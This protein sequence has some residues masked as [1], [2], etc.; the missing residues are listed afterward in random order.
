MQLM[1]KNP[2]SKWS[3]GLPIG[4]GRLAAMVWGSVQADVLTLNHEWLWRGT[5]RNRKV[6][7]NA[8]K[9]PFVRDLL[10]RGEFF[11]AG[12]FANLYFGGDGG[13]SGKPNN[14]DP[15]VP[16]G[17]LTFCFD[18]DAQ[19]SGRELDINTGIAETKR[20]LS[21][22]GVTGEFYASCVS[23]L[24]YAKWESEAP[25]SGTLRL[26]REHE[27]ITDIIIKAGKNK[28]TL[29]GSINNGQCF[30]IDV[31]IKTDGTLSKADDG[32]KVE[33]AAELSC[34]INIAVSV[35]D[36]EAELG[37]YPAVFDD[38]SGIKKQHIDT[39]SERMGRIG[40]TL[41]DEQRYEDIPLEERLRMLRGGGKDNG[42][43]TLLYHYGRYLLIS[44]TISGELPPNLQG[45]WNNMLN[46]P[47]ECDYHSDINV[48]MAHWSVESCNLPECA[49]NLFFF[50]ESFYESGT[51]AA[52]AL[53]GCRGL[54]MPLMTDAWGIST[55]EAFGWAVWIGAAPWLA[56][57]FWD[58]Y[59]YTG[60]IG[61][62]RNRAYPYFQAVAEF[63]EDYVERDS[64]S[65]G[66]YQ[67][68]PSQSPENKFEGVGFL[69]V[70]LCVSAAMDVQLC[71][72]LL[73]Y[74]LE[75]ARLLNE[76]DKAKTAKWE[77]IRSHLPPFGIGKDGRL[78]EWND[79]KAEVEDEL[80]HRHL[81]HLYGVYPS[82]IFAPG[83]P[84]YNAARKSFDFR[85]SHGGGHTGWS[86]AW[87][88]ALMARFGDGEGFH[89]H[90]TQLLREF[91][92]ASL[93]D[94]HPPGIFQIDGNLGAPA[95]INEALISA[96]NGKI[97]LLRALPE[98]WPSGG[99][100]GIKTPGGHI[101]DIEWKN[102]RA[103]ELKIIIG[104]A[105]KAVFVIDGK[106]K[107]ITGKAGDD[108]SVDLEQ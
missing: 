100:R 86:R 55:P 50:L 106:E 74:A 83:T 79:E 3:E 35:K 92:T 51:E 63:Y 42:L 40:F 32:F 12:V 22:R 37:K 56:R 57:H 24:I 49:G 33:G 5:N 19:F 70:G 104:F 93:L 66:Y 23:G 88:A 91:S 36:I 96:Q 34:I 8:D 59:R 67:I 64:V 89:E 41:C 80:G 102:G 73:G 10:R 48:Q 16:A 97:Y 17:E 60:D 94:L 81:S 75:S 71:Y 68:I 4:N 45:K 85:M 95:A 29:E 72:D 54:Y 39:F 69:P 84:E 99:L 78:L 53:Y 107:T 76:P 14:I 6:E 9:L 108:I 2:P 47:W 25:F 43:I 11:E 90:I 18:D 20:Q 28:L 58:H 61:F 87:C 65:D 46:P 52:K 101:V 26:S 13:L 38:L 21:G 103:H 105:G 31:H 27:D 1:L 30:K 62:L 98:Q 44:S 77:D 7:D 15:Y 82:D